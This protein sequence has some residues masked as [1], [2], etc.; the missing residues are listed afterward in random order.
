M[1]RDTSES[2]LGRVKIRLTSKE[3]NLVVICSLALKAHSTEIAELAEWYRNP[4]VYRSLPS[5]QFTFKDWL[6]LILL[7]QCCQLSYQMRVLCESC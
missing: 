3:T 1:Y 7:V 5:F 4:Y 6:N 2:K